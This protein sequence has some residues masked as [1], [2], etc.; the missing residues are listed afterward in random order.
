MSQ[1]IRRTRMRA[2]FLVGLAIVVA[3]STA[4][5]AWQVVRQYEDRLAAA[6]DQVV[7]TKVVVAKRDLR[8]GVSLTAADVELIDW[9][10]PL[11]PKLVYATVEEVVGITVGDRVLVG[12]V[13]RKERLVDGG[14]GLDIHELLEPGTRAVT[15]RSDRAAGV[16]GL[17]RPGHIVDVIVTIRPD[18]NE[19]DAKWVTETILQ[20]VHVIAVNDEVGNVV[21]DKQEEV[22]PKRR[23]SREMYIT[24]EVRP[25]EAEQIALATSRG[26]VHIAL[27]AMDDFERV[28][29]SGPL[30]TNRLMGLPERVARA[31]ERRMARV[32]STPEVKPAANP[33]AHTTEVIRGDQM[34]V[35]QFDK[36]GA[37]IAPRG[38]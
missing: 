15:I 18:G 2:G 24:L 16:G 34:T 23:K 32:T 35:E 27:R 19:M 12:E 6:Q 14:A 13:L 1:P 11:D 33:A 30:V 36:D 3:S 10:Q 25:A 26:E 4:Y 8:A 29:A 22:D 20:G 38:R 17:L 9:A 37:R 7:H 31:Q 5:A 28:E 21:E